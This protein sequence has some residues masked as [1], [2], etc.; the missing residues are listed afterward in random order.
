[1]YRIIL[2]HLVCNL[3]V[4]A[5]FHPVPDA[6]LQALDWSNYNRFF[7]QPQDLKIPEYQL[8]PHLAGNHEIYQIILDVTCFSRQSHSQKTRT[9]QVDVWLS[10]VDYLERRLQCYYLGAPEAP[11]S[12]FTAKY[13]LY[14]L[15]LRIYC[16]K[17][18]DHNLLA[19]HPLVASILSEAQGVFMDGPLRHVYHPGIA[20]PFVV[21]MCACSNYGKFQLFAE[22]VQMIMM[23]FDP[24]HRRHLEEVITGLEQIFRRKGHGRSPDNLQLLLRKEGVTSPFV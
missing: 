22:E 11:A 15:A 19:N 3:A 7:S 5:L 12:M 9:Y 4:N 6:V 23:N 2:E 14:L 8:S 18:K 10:R 17:V 1:M 13:Q 24:G 16:F 21:L 20:W